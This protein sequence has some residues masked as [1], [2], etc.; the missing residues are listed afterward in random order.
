MRV[1][2]RSLSF[3]PR[4]RTALNDALGGGAAS[5][6]NTTYGLSYALLIFA[7]PLAPYLSYGIATTFISSAVLAI[8]I[9]LGAP[10]ADPIIGLLITGL[11]LRITWASWKTVT[12]P[13]SH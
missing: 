6:L 2:S 5:V 10:I 12:G 8:V 9:A 4:I 13:R 1:V 3:G 7:G 11:I